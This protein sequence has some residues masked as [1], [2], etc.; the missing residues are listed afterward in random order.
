MHDRGFLWGSTV[1]CFNVPN[2]FDVGWELL[3][4]P[5]SVRSNCVFVSLFLF[6]LDVEITTKHRVKESV[7]FSGVT[8][9]GFAK[10]VALV[11]LR[12]CN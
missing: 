11:V 3:L 8:P 1:D 12:Q 9:L 2:S 10:F 6:S 7:R 5:Y 4:A